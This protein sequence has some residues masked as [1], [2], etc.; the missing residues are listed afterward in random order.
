MKLRH[1]NETEECKNGFIYLCLE[2]IVK[3]LKKLNA[4]EWLKNFVCFIT[5]NK[6]IETI[7]SCKNLAIDFFI[8]F[9]WLITFLAFYYFN[10]R[11]LHILVIYLIVFNI[12]TYFYYHVWNISSGNTS[13]ARS[14]RRFIST[15]QAI[16]YNVFGYAYL[17]AVPFSGYFNWDEK[18]SKIV[19]A[20]NLSVSNTFLGSSNVT[21]NG[22][23]G[24]VI[25]LTQYISTFVLITIILSTAFPVDKK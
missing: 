2:I 7:I 9:K 19:S 6:K 13:L 11:F 20:L 22:E 24:I 10:N 16:F 4:V 23:I 21:P 14:R 17:Y 5:P 1:E 18:V 15:V 25:M 12:F 8:V 3:I